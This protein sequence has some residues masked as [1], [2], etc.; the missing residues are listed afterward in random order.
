[1]P[2]KKKSASKKPAKKKSPAKA[3]VGLVNRNQRKQ[4]EALGYTSKPKGRR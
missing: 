1:M 4:L 2:A 3:G